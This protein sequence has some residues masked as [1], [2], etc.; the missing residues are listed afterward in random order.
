ME[1]WWTLSRAL[2]HHPM[3]LYSVYKKNTEVYNR[4]VFIDS[5]SWFV[6]TQEQT[7][8]ILFS[9]TQ[10]LL[11]AE[12]QKQDRKWP[13]SE[14]RVDR[15]LTQLKRS[16]VQNTSMNE[17]IDNRTWRNFTFC[18]LC[19]LFI[20]PFLHPSLP[21]IC[22]LMFYITESLTAWK[23]YSCSSTGTS[24]KELKVVQRRRRRREKRGGGRGRGDEGRSKS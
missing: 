2:V 1:Q 15:A 20:P 14:R 5:D 8:W 4:L 9:V 3:M 6:Y 18:S 12:L 22:L 19:S 10:R 13:W 21:S 11:K 7:V 16:G 24:H 17:A 23:H